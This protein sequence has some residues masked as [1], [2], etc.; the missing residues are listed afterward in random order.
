MLDY[1]KLSV[2]LKNDFILSL[3]KLRELDILMCFVL[4]KNLCKIMQ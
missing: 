1:S 3:Y 2:S 4:K